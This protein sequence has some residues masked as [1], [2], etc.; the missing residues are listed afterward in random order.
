MIV[1]LLCILIFCIRTLRKRW[2]EV[3]L[4]MHIIGQLQSVCLCFDVWLIV[5]Q[6][7]L[8]GAVLVLAG[9]MYH[10]PRLVGWV[11]APIGLWALER[12]ARALRCFTTR[13][14]LRYPLPL[15]T[16]TLLD[17]GAIVLRVPFKGTWSSGQHA[18]LSF[19][20][21]S[22]ADAPHPFSIANVPVVTDGGGD[23]VNEML[24][25]MGVRGGLTA[26]IAKHL[27]DFSS[28]S[29]QL[30]VAVEGPYGSSDSPGR[31]DEIL[32]IAGGTGITHICSSKSGVRNQ[33]S[34]SSGS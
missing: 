3:F 26:S 23:L 31:Y 8:A 2:Y 20:G 27:E 19:P 14:R 9:L 6:S 5:R 32:L 29:T 33:N 30:R 11:W 12:T 34:A 15:A 22:L 17:G 4:T 25:V 7:D 1:G 10:V 13:L 28:R 21:L 18:Y 16:A 24:F